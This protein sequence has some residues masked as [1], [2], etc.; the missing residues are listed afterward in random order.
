M[1][2]KKQRQT[3]NQIQVIFAGFILG[4]SLISSASYADDSKEALWKDKK[5]GLTWMRCSIGQQWS[6]DSCKGTGTKVTWQEAVDYLSVFNSQIALGGH[7]DWRLPTIVELASIRHCNKH[8]ARED[9]YKEANRATIILRK[10]P[11]RR[12]QRSIPYHC[13]K[14]SR[15]PTIT[16]NIFPNTPAAPFWSA[17]SVKENADSAWAV[18]FKY[19]YT[20]YFD[21]DAR[22]YMRLVRSGK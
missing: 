18:G 13:S 16:R 3:S 17:S 14:D 21:K 11:N 5:T 20:G 8:W 4:V 10:V 22:F 6:K 12:A 19:G 9:G 15:S 2:D 1:S 7:S